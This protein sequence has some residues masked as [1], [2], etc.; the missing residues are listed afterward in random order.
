M[1]MGMM[2]AVIMG[3]LGIVYARRLLR[4]NGTLNGYLKPLAY[5]YLIGSICF[6]LLVFAPLGLVLFRVGDIILGLAFFKGDE[7]EELEV[8]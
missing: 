2:T 1:V 7:L 6:V 8:V 5:S 4:M 3:V